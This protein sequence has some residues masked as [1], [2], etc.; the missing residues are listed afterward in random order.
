MGAMSSEILN[1]EG[2]SLCR[3]L[4]QIHIEQAALPLCVGAADESI[5]VHVRAQWLGMLADPRVRQR[6]ELDER[7]LELGTRTGD[8]EVAEAAVATILV[9]AGPG[10]LDWVREH[11]AALPAPAAREAALSALDSEAL[12]GLVASLLGTSIGEEAVLQ[13]FDWLPEK[14]ASL[15]CIEASATRDA[16]IRARAASLLRSIRGERAQALRAHWIASGQDPVVVAILTDPPEN[17]TWTTDSAL[18]PPDANPY[19]D[20]PRAWTYRTIGS[21]LHWLE[22]GYP[23]P[24]RCDLVRIHEVNAAGGIIAVIGI[25]PDGVERTLWQG[26]DPTVNPGVFEVRVE[27]PA[28]VVSKIRLEIDANRAR[29]WFEIDAVE[30]VG[31]EGRSWATTAR[32]SSSF[33]GD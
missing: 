13:A 8:D 29:T 26:D 33:G 12:P 27:P 3:A 30:I 31:P 9:R 11:Y 14:E 6:A 32:A 5:P 17:A 18:G 24:M 7:L 22:L 19:E 25:D 21:G 4:L 23:R 1:A 20:D 15:A 16:S 2:T 28:P 10:A